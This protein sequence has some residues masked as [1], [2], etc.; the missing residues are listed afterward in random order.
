MGG[1]RGSG[2]R[3]H[4]GGAWA[5]RVPM[6]VLVDS[7]TASASEVLSGALKDNSRA[8]VVGDEATFGKGLVQTTVGLSDGSGLAITVARYLT[9]SGTDINKVG[10]SPDRQGGLDQLPA[11]PSKFCDALTPEAVARIFG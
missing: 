1:H 9:P 4:G 8:V 3:Y 7:G 10:I 6:A 11:E 5:K 2:P